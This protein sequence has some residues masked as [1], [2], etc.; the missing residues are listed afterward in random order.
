M[1]T[2]VFHFI[3]IKLLTQHMEAEAF[4]IYSLILIVS[5]G[6]QILG[7]LGLNLCLVRNLS[8]ELAED[9]KETVSTIFIARFIQLILLAGLVYALGNLFLPRLFDASISSY[10]KYI[11]LIFF[12]ASFRDLLFNLLQGV[13]LFNRYAIINILSAGIRLLTI[14]VFV[15][16]RDLTILSM[17]F[18]EVITYGISLLLLLIYSPVKRYLT[19]RISTSNVK[20]VFSFSVPL[21]AND[22]LTYV[23]N[24]VSVLLIAGLLTPISVAKY[25][26]ASK[27]PEGFGRLFTSLIV[28]YF[29]SVSELLSAGDYKKAGA[30]MNRGLII[31]STGLS[32][33]TLVVFLFRE[34][35]ILLLTDEKYLDASMALALL[36]LNFSVNAIARVMGYTVVAAGHSSVPVRINL[37]SSIINIVGCLILIPRF[38]FEGAIYSMVTMSTIS[39][40]LNALFL[41]KA[42]IKPDLL[43][44]ARPTLILVAIAVIYT[45][46]GNTGFV[47]RGLAILVFIGSAWLLIPEVKQAAN[48][49]KNQMIKRAWNPS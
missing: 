15:L 45:V 34:E 33:V 23:Y 11:P 7:G 31:A 29:P 4:G 9:K 38:G 2:I 10:I 16:Q 40:L 37:I 5:H 3:S 30:F 41:I 49:A 35:I 32:L 12:L 22:I 47:F 1:F 42:S 36:M 20:K 46:F 13:K 19:F 24:K 48:F 44:F 8:D 28:V 25:E 18:V 27:V 17:V 39:Q 21:Y 43:G 26:V 14:V 6:F